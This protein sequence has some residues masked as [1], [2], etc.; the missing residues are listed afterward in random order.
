MKFFSF[1]FFCLPEHRLPV[2]P[3]VFP[4]ADHV[5][6][7]FIQASRFY[8]HPEQW[9][10]TLTIVKEVIQILEI[11][12]KRQSVTW[13]TESPFDL[14]W[15]TILRACLSLTLV[16]VARYIWMYINCF[17]SNQT[18]KDLYGSHSTPGEEELLNYNWIKLLVSCF[19]FKKQFQMII[20]TIG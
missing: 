6:L 20:G 7:K 10:I 14:N 15:H 19:Y 11:L 17:Y 18:C 8:A 1:F 5:W 3:G 16:P 9:F 13:S 4:Q 2:T 12:W